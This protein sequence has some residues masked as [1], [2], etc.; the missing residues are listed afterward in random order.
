MCLRDP[1]AGLW[2]VTVSGQ[3]RQRNMVWRAAPLGSE[4]RQLNSSRFDPSKRRLMWRVTW[5]FE[6]ADYSV[7]DE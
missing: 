7:T 3:A 2:Q 6:G 1:L 4:W 5:R